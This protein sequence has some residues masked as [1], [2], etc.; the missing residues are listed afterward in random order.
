MISRGNI[1]CLAVC[2]NSSSGI[3][4][5]DYFGGVRCAFYSVDIEKQELLQSFM[6]EPLDDE[7]ITIKNIDM[8]YK[9]DALYVFRKYG[10]SSLNKSGFYFPENRLKISVYK[11][12]KS[13]YQ[14]NILSAVQE[15][16]QYQLQDENI[17]KTFMRDYYFI[18]IK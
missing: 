14:G 11:G 15:D 3:Y 9:N 12:N 1:I 2:S 17:G 13:V 5:D 4:A 7:L 18:R 8:I 10:I 6:E 16:Y